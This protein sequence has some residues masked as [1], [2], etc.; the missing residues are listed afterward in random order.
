MPKSE[1][2]ERLLR[3]KVLLSENHMRCCQK[4]NYVKVIKVLITNP[5]FD[6]KSSVFSMTHICK[7]HNSRY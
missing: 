2:C 6:I 4:I 1:T 7:I 5:L 3:L